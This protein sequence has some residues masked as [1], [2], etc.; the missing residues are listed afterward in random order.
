MMDHLHKERGQALVIMVFAILA[1]LTVAGLAIDG[2]MAFL[3]RRRMQNAADAAALAGTRKLAEAVC[4]E[5]GADD[6]AIHAEVLNYAQLN[7]VTD[8]NLVSAW[9]VDKDINDIGVVGAG[10]IPNGALGVRA[11]VGI[12]HQT[13]FIRLLGMDEAGADAEAT[14]VTG[15]PLLAGGLRPFGVPVELVADLGGGDPFDVTFKND[16]GEICWSGNCVEHRGWMNMGYLW[17]QTE[18]PTFDRAVDQGADANVLKEWMEQGWRGN[19]FAD[20]RGWDT[21]CRTGDYIHAKPGTN[22]SAICKAPQDPTIIQIPVY[23]A[24]LDCPAEPIPDPK[25]ACPTQGGGWC[26]HIV[27]IAN[28]KI[29][30]CNQG[31][32]E[33]NLELVEGITYGI[34]YLG[35]ETGY[36]GSQACGSGSQVVTL[37]K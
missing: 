24:I 2:G 17:N 5:A 35:S 25:P 37:W 36:G 16:G 20:C 28:V 1:L 30:D 34:P 19:V 9:Y 14:A 21:G 31:G 15:P 11:L 13:Y 22:S 10:S 27:S 32:G 26:Y 4:G 12:S 29:T 18:D 23:D 33:I 7:G 3:D 8:T 6:A